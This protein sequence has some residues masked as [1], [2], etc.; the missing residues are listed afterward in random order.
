MEFGIPLSQC[1]TGV[2]VEIVRLL[3][4]D[5]N[6]LRKLM[7]FGVFPGTQLCVL[8]TFPAVV[9]E[10]GYTQLALDYQIAEKI[11]VNVI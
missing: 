5:R 10:I 2:R 11:L 9:I 3:I 7:V 8:Q 1:R 6:N 4:Q